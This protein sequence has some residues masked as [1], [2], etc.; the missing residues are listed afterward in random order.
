MPPLRLVLAALVL[1]GLADVSSSGEGKLAY[2]KLTEGYWQIW[3]SESSGAEEWQLTTGPSDKHEP[4]WRP[5]G[6]GLVYCDSEGRLFET[7]LGSRRADRLLAALEPFAEPHLSPTGELVY[8]RVRQAPGYLADLWASRLDGSDARAVTQAPLRH[9]QPAWSPDGRSIAAIENDPEH[10]TQALVVLDAQTRTSRRLHWGRNRLS[11]PA[12]SPDARAIAFVMDEGGNNDLWLLEV[13]EDAPRRLTADPALDAAPEFS[14]DGTEILFVSTRSGTQQLWRIPT[15]GGRATQVTFGDTPRREP[16]WWGRLSHPSRHFRGVLL[17]RRV[18]DPKF[19]DTCEVTFEATEPGSAPRMDVVDAAG[20]IVRS[21]IQ[22]S[23]ASDSHLAWDGTDEGGAPVS[24]L[25]FLRLVAEDEAGEVRWDPSR[26]SGGEY[27]SVSGLT[28]NDGEERVEFVL[29]DLALV[30]VRVGLAE[31]PLLS[32]PMNWRVLGPGAAVV[33]VEG[34]GA[35]GWPGLWRMPDRRTWVT[36]WRLPDNAIW[37]VGDDAEA[38]ARED[39]LHHY[40][41]SQRK[42]FLHALHEPSACR[43]VAVQATVRPPEGSTGTP[44]P[45]VADRASIRIDALT[46]R[47]RRLLEDSRFEVMIYI[48]GQFLFEDEDAALPYSYTLDVS[49]FPEGEH[50]FLAVVAGYQDHQG[51]AFASFRIERG[52]E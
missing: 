51:A 44:G 26:S 1:C 2:S 49:R 29:D 22:A 41:G 21:G 30:R 18:L 24:G 35:P 5:D 9:L 11:T 45:V 12:W 7:D 31:G 16:A 47:D 40:R 8:Q 37:V 50:S 42:L 19:G 27:V 28:L 46:D 13:G 48:D 17:S 4:T 20:R 25:H 38:L 10:D 33:P 52:E 3:V 14:P 36:S 23:T 32:A 6:T 15:A 43:D 39:W 34:I